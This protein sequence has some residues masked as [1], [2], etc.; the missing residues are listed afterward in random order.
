VGTTRSATLPAS[1]RENQNS[2]IRQGNINIVGNQVRGNQNGGQFNGGIISGQNR[3]SQNFQAGF[4][5]NG[6]L[7]GESRPRNFQ[8]PQIFQQSFSPNPSQFQQIIGNQGQQFI[9]PQQN[10]QFF[11]SQQQG[12]GIQPQAIANTFNQISQFIPNSAT[13]GIAN[14]WDGSNNGGLALGIGNNRGL[15]FGFGNNPGGNPIVIYFKN[16]LQYF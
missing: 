15:G 16:V 8:R 1:E 2:N 3:G 9:Q 14:S 5:S 13:S 6:R 4:S 10:Q 11:T 12:F 7:I